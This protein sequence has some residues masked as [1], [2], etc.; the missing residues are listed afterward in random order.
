M[1]VFVSYFC[2]FLKLLQFL[3]ICLI[4]FFQLSEEA[5]ETVKKASAGYLS[6]LEEKF[7]KLDYKDYSIYTGSCGLALVYLKLFKITNERD[8][9]RVSDFLKQGFSNL[10][11]VVPRAGFST[12]LTRGA[13]I[14]EGPSDRMKIT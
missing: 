8:F 6:L 14:S 11:N 10:W 1:L 3:K 9:I 5:K 12:G 4:V 13:S 7:Y 2:D